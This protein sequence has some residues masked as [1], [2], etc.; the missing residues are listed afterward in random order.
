MVSGIPYQFLIYK[1][2]IKKGGSSV[3]SAQR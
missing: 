3:L 2:K 1:N